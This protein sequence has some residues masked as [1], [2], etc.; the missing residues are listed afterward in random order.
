[1]KIVGIVMLLVSLI[2][3]LIAGYTNKP[4]S[5]EEINALGVGVLS[6]IGGCIYFA[7]GGLQNSK[8]K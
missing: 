5:K 8:S 3:F 2:A 1:M 4:I 7:A 6:F